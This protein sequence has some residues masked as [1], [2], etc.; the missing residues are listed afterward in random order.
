MWLMTIN[1][2]VDD[3]FIF[4]T[5]RALQFSR[6]PLVESIVSVLFYLFYCY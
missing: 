1:D 2:C 5:D 3:V 4:E 6:G